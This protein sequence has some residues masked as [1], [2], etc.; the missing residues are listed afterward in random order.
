[1][2]MNSLIMDGIADMIYFQ[3]DISC[4]LNECQTSRTHFKG[5]YLKIDSNSDAELLLLALKNN[6][7]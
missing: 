5:F 6:Q 7:H 1:M 4:V 2:T 3:I